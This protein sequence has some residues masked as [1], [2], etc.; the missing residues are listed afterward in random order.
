[1]SDFVNSNEI[2]SGGDKRPFTRQTYRDSRYNGYN[3]YSRPYRPNYN[4]NKKVNF[5][6]G[7]SGPRQPSQLFHNRTFSQSNSNKAFN[8]KSYNPRFKNNSNFP[9]NSFNSQ[10]DEF[11]HT[12]R[13]ENLP[14]SSTGESIEEVVSSP[15][16]DIVDNV[17]R[18]SPSTLPQQPPTPPV[19]YVYD[20]QL[21]QTNWP[22][23]H[24]HGPVFQT[25]NGPVFQGPVYPYSPAAPTSPTVTAVQTSSG[26]VHYYNYNPAY[27]PMSFYPQPESVGV[28]P[29]Q[30]QQTMVPPGSM[31]GYNDSP[32]GDW[33]NLAAQNGSRYNTTYY[34]SP[35]SY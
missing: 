8:W 23:V 3:G 24:S 21:Q 30:N 2:E 25:H 22:P 15:P 26:L 1:M 17:A 28:G 13:S 16:P 20:Q 4:N 31:M 27:Q 32:A 34:P 7:R 14:Q 6:N 33:N 19:V 29:W 5:E 11:S 35:P 9:L 12:L 18:P 10:R